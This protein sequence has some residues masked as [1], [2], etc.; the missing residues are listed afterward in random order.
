MVY[1]IAEKLSCWRLATITQKF[2]RRCRRG[3]P[4]ELLIPN[5]YPA[6]YVMFFTHKNDIVMG[7]VCRHNICVLYINNSN[8]ITQ[9]IQIINMYSI[10]GQNRALELLRH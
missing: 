2:T 8:I 10:S 4:S 7:F 6:V 3:M 5:F 1:V 9:E